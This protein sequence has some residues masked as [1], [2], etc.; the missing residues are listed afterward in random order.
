MATEE[1]IR[2]AQERK[3]MHEASKRRDYRPLSHNHEL[4]GLSAERAWTDAFGGSVDLELRPRGDKGHDFTL[5][6]YTVDVKGAR[7]SHRLLVKAGKKKYADIFV[8]AHYDDETENAK[9]VGWAWNE[10]VLA[11]TPKDSGFG[12]VN[13]EVPARELHPIDELW[14]IAHAP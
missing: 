1:M 11:K 7:R 14:D 4:V 5:N 3:A 8:L 10:E 6:G 12:I 9:L 2:H 13:Y